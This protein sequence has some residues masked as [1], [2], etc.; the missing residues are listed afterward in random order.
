MVFYLCFKRFCSIS[1]KKQFSPE[2]SIKTNEKSVHCWCRF[3]VK[4]ASETASLL[5][6]N[7]RAQN[8]DD[9]DG[10]V[11]WKLLKMGVSKNRD[12]SPKTNMSPKKGLFQ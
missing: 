3:D 11:T 10:K 5:R 9:L 8:V 12:T 6:G 2:K 7:L 1:Y 4:E